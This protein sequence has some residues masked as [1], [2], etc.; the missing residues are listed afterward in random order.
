METIWARKVNVYHMREK[1]QK[2]TTETWD[3]IKEK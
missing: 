1:K 2:H 3:C